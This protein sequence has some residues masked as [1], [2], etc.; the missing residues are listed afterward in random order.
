MPLRIVVANEPRIYR[1]VL[2]GAL[3]ALRASYTVDLVD[4]D[5]LDTTVAQTAPDVV[6]ATAMSPALQAYQGL[7]L[8]LYAPE[9]NQVVLRKAG[10]VLQTMEQAEFTDILA[11]IDRYASPPD[12]NPSEPGA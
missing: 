1:E 3:S 11:L 5:Q 10:R 7:L 12:R 6:I 4:P 2:A 8:L 9:A